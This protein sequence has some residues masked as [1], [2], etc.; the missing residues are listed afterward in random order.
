MARKHPPPSPR[1][2]SGRVILAANPPMAPLCKLLQHPHASQRPDELVQAC[3]ELAHPPPP[4][5]L[6]LPCTD[7][8]HVC[9]VA[10]SWTRSCSR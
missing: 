9:P 6:L 1:C 2:R 7:S 3:E 4:L 5:L 8:V 10:L